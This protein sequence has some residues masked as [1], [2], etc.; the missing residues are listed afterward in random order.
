METLNPVV[1]NDILY[2]IFSRVDGSTLAT[3]ACAG[4]AFRSISLDE[5]IW[6]R[7]CNLQWPSTKDYRVKSIVRSLGGFQKFYSECFPLVATDEASV[8]DS[9]STSRQD[10]ENC[11]DNKMQNMIEEFSCSSL[12]D[13][14]SIIDVIFRGKP[15]F[16]RVLHG[17]PGAAG[18]HGWFSTCPFRIDALASSE[19]EEDLTIGPGNIS[20][21]VLP[22]VFSMDKESEV[23]PEV[24]SMD[25]ERK[26]G[27][28]WKALLEG[29][30]ISWV[31]INKKTKQMVN[32]SSWRPLGGQRHW[33]TDDSFSL[34]FGS[35]LPG[36]NSSSCKLAW[37]NLVLNCKL[38]SSPPDGVAVKTNLILSE[39]SLQLEDMACRHLNGKESMKTLFK[40]LTCHKSVDH[41]EVL[42]NDYRYIIAQSEMKEEKM[43]A[44]GWIEIICLACGI[45]PFVSTLC[46]AFLNWN[47]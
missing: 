28:L 41:C 12:H 45:M 1:S 5:S 6:E 18:F 7:I 31:L 21:E 39:L 30:R 47:F 16:S 40:A 37:C 17:I 15:V 8:S 35:I 9:F 44:D 33:P 4:S 43:K 26:D 46:Y 13:F 32:L 38:Q 19:E 24:F 14:T 23:L 25:K 22:E 29:F 11:L 27:K 20:S 2:E 42:K 34:R 3:A 10:A 36:L